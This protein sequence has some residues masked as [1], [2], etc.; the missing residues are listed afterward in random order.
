MTT[1]STPPTTSPRRT[2]APT[3][4]TGVPAPAGTATAVPDAA[5]PATAGT[6]AAV[7][8]AEE[9]TTSVPATTAPD[10]VTHTAAETTAATTAG[11]A[12]SAA[13]P[14]AGGPAVPAV[15]ALAEAGAG[16][17]PVTG[18][19]L[20]LAG[21]PGSP[22]GEVA[23]ELRLPPA[24]AAAVGG[25]LLPRPLFAA[26]RHVARA[27]DDAVRLFELI[28][29]LPQRLYDGDLAAY[30]RALG[31]D[32]RT[33]RLVTRLG[34]A[35]PP[36]YGRTD[37]G[38][39]GETFRLLEFNIASELGGI[40]RAGLIPRLWRQAAGFCEFAA[41]HRLGHLD[42]ARLVAATL[43][44]AARTV[45]GGHRTPVVALLEAPGGLTAFGAVWQ[46]LAEL[47]R[48]QGLDFR[49]GE[50]QDIRRRGERI[51]L[52][53]TGVD[54]VLRCFSAEELLATPD[55]EELA[56]PVL[57]AHAAGTAV[58]WVPLEAYL[59]SNKG[60]LAL[61]SQPHARRAF[62]GEERALIDRVLPWTRTLP[63]APQTHAAEVFEE[64][65]D[66]QQELI[67][68]PLDQYGG[69][70]I[71]PGWEVPAVRWRQ[72]LRTVGTSGAVV[73]QRV[74]LRPEPVLDADTG[75]IS[76]WRTVWSL[77]VTP[78]GHAGTYARALPAH[79]GSV[80]GMGISPSARTAG[81]FTFPDRPEAAAAGGGPR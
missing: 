5:V 27:A 75:E 33:R 67:L 21:V 39:D 62:T 40:D 9:A 19:F 25:R 24:V 47:M 70:G 49:V 45:T 12:V 20:R 77:F 26:E 6:T 11:N 66:R 34:G 17:D 13:V 57:R 31:I 81:V 56:E 50:V 76:S 60:C 38:Y 68:K 51:T 15:A 48:E 18:A 44:R 78:E 55:G 63:A 28:T 54:L 58:L 23:R 2:P 73:Q 61:L 74:P 43:H 37:M 32:E 41:E 4:A 79:E 46:G 65:V 10:A 64:C 59:F 36:M 8:A 35:P 42:T 72:L 69:S 14:A 71:V 30:C 1:T 16:V 53:G 3:R 52:G 80:V 22:L 29:S 7:S